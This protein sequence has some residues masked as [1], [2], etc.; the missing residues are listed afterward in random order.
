MLA[1]VAA[2][3][4]N[5]I[6]GIDGLSASLAVMGFVHVNLAFGLLAQPTP[7]EILAIIMLMWAAVR[8]PA[9]QSAGVF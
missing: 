8:F 7:P 6:D 5:F 2:T 1:V 3:N 4:A 9:V